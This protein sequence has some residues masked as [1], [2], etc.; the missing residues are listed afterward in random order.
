M[1]SGMFSA[2]EHTP[3][4]F[5]HAPRCLHLP[6]KHVKLLIYQRA[7][8][9]NVVL[10]IFHEM[11]ARSLWR[12]NLCWDLIVDGLILTLSLD[13]DL[14]HSNT[15]CEGVILWEDRWYRKCCNYWGKCLG[16]AIS[17]ITSSTPPPSP[18][19]EEVCYQKLPTQ[20]IQT[21]LREADEA[22]LLDEEGEPFLFVF[23]MPI[24]YAFLLW[25]NYGPLHS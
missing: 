25:F 20:Y 21:E 18:S 24:T 19:P 8:K 22:N 7:N 4:Q 14:I 5:G 15:K 11:V 9:N 23:Q 16:Y 13:F 10:H 3:K 17:L 6:S 1:F 12:C 2:W